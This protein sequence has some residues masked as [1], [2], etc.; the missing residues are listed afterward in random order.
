MR[1]GGG[2]GGGGGVRGLLTILDTRG[3]NHVPE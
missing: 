3:V 2:G 1:G